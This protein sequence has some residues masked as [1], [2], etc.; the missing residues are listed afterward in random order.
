MVNGKKLDATLLLFDVDG[1]LV[2][3]EDRYKSLAA[4]RFNAIEERAGRLAAETWA[5]LG[6]YDPATRT[7]DMSGAVAKAARREDMAIAAAGIYR[8]GKG[9]HEARALAEVAYADADA[10]QMRDYTPKLFPGVE[11]SLRRLK[12]QGFTLGIAT[13]GS[14]KITT[15]LMEILRVQ[16]LFAVVTGS[17]D[18]TNPKPAPDVL[19]AACT[20]A[21]K[22]PNGVVYVGDQVV[23]A[24]AA[25]AAGCA[26]C[27]IVGRATVPSSPHVHRLPSVADLTRES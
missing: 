6:G 27:I 22:Q 4:L 9:W 20:K 15:Q 25:K 1:T 17:E 16:D 21:G 10:V 14:N 19:L 8:T 7:I 12:A 18:V 5:P 24:E 13:N 26:G 2:D 3:D 11:K 23:D